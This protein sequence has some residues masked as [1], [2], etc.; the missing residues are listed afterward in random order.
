MILLNKVSLW[1]KWF[2]EAEPFQT[3]KILFETNPCLNFLDAFSWCHITKERM[4]ND[5]FSSVP[6][7]L[8][9]IVS[10][11][12]F[13]QLFNLPARTEFE[14]IS[15]RFVLFQHWISQIGILLWVFSRN[16]FTKP[17]LVQWIVGFLQENVRSQ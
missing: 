17:A 11:N 15:E 6:W 9:F 14:L 12:F 4:C 10:G 16:L 2:W 13:V 7:K 8:C 5:S 1:Y 3:L